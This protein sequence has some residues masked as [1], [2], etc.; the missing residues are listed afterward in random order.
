M[1]YFLKVQ[2]VKFKIWYYKALWATES[3]TAKALKERPNDYAEYSDFAILKK[4]EKEMDEFWEQYDRGHDLMKQTVNRAKSK[5]KEANRLAYENTL[6]AKQLKKTIA[7]GT[8]DA[9]METNI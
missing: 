9:N 8:K 7:Q 5:K 6:E 4:I 1:I 3:Y 2:L